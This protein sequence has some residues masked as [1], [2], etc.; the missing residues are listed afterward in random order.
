MNVFINHECYITIELTFLKE[1][2]VIRQMNPKSAIF[3]TTGIFLNKRFKFQSYLCY[4]CHDVI[5][6]QCCY[7]KNKNAL[8]LIVVVLLAELVSVKL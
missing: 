8:L 6:Q 4:R 1:L 7:F 2:M 3:V 5:I